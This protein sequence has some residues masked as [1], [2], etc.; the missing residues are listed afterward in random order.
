MDIVEELLELLDAQRGQEVR[1]ARVQVPFC[2]DGYRLP[3]NIFQL[4]YAS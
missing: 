4:Q 2:R 3:Q 1:T